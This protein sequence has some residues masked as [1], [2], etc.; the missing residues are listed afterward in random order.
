MLEMWV[1]LY[2][3]DRNALRSYLVPLRMRG[4]WEGVLE[5]LGTMYRLSPGDA[6]LL[7]EMADA[8]LRLGNDDDALAVL[9]EYME[10][11]PEDY[12]GLVSLAGVHW[13]RGEYDEARGY[14][15]RAIFLEPRLP[16]I[17]AELAQL[18]LDAGR[19]DEAREGYERA[20]ELA[21]TPAQ[22]TEVLAGLKRYY[23]VRGEAENTVATANRWWRRRPGMR[24]RYPSWRLAST[25]SPPTSALGAT[26]RRWRAFAEMS[27]TWSKCRCFG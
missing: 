25:I 1:E 24:R 5:T 3:E 16:S 9:S 21:R 2:P 17:V 6:D 18:N 19:F 26:K 12:S 7:K 8:H 10:Q 13:G 22:R 4:D 27:L 23:S 11:F 14:L 20:M 15:E